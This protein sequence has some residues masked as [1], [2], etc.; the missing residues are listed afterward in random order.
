MKNSKEILNTMIE[1]HALIEVLL[2]VFKNDLTKEPGSAE[3]SLNKF[4][5]ELEK[6]F[7]VEERAIFKFCG[8]PD[9][10]IC[11]IVQELIQEH[12]IMLEMLN[13]IKNDLVIGKNIEI[14]SFLIL[15]EK[16]RNTEEK[17]LYPKIDQEFSQENKDI[18]ISK[19]NE[20]PLKK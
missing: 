8:S 9:S 18:I 13:E 19:I 1:E 3:N 20:I 2:L 14:S 17:K 15:L 12:S 16:H 10:E 11:Q 7:F 6:H 5:W 4:S